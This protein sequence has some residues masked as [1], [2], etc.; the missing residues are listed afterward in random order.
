MS[1]EEYHLNEHNNKESESSERSRYIEIYPPA[2]LI[3]AIISNDIEA[4]KYCITRGDN[5]NQ[6]ECSLA[7]RSGTT[8]LLEAAQNGNLKIFKF[9]IKAGANINMFDHFGFTALTHAAFMEHLEIINYLISKNANIFISGYGGSNALIGAVHSNNIEI[10]KTLINAG[11]KTELKNKIG[12]LALWLTV[13]YGYF[14]TLEIL[15]KEGV[16]VNAWLLDGCISSVMTAACYG[17]VKM[18][19]AKDKEEI[20]ETINNPYNKYDVETALKIIQI[21]VEAGA[22]VNDSNL[23]GDTA[24]FFAVKGGEKKIIELLLNLGAE[25]NEVND[26]GWSALS[27]AI[28]KDD[29]SIVKLLLMHGAELSD[30]DYINSQNK[31]LELKKCINS[32]LYAQIVNDYDPEIFYAIK[33]N[34]DNHD[35][36]RPYL[37]KALNGLKKQISDTLQEANE[38]IHAVNVVSEI[39]DDPNIDI[40]TNIAGDDAQ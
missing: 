8:P 17:N 29:A 4:V 36:T 13:K 24:L 21:L 23:L 38:L 33:Q 18:L 14:D 12:D 1:L 40:A 34:P 10:V 2:P 9:L 25:I 35:N 11:F 3:L 28:E 20:E 26:K 30:E 5:V 27:F 19:N 16:N 31:S 7:F 15:I 32:V 37:Q 39:V 6:E 22:K